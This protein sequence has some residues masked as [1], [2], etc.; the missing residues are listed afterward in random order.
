MAGP[1]E[2]EIFTGRTLAERDGKPLG[3]HTFVY[4]GDQT[5][6]AV[7]EFTEMARVEGERER[8]SDRVEWEVQ[9]LHHPVQQGYAEQWKREEQ[10]RISDG[11]TQVGSEDG[12]G[13]SSGATLRVTDHEGRVLVE[14]KLVRRG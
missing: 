13:K 3:V 14:E 7:R 2:N 10:R 5:P 8:E 9:E 12:E 11:S 1:G 6:P 4:R